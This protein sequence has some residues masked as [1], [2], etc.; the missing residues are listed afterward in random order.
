MRDDAS[1]STVRPPGPPRALDPGRP[2]QVEARWTRRALRA[3]GRRHRGR[4]R[5]RRRAR[6][7]RLAEP[8]RARRADRPATASPR[9]AGSTIDLQPARWSLRLVEGDASAS[10]AALCVVR[11]SEGRWL[12]GRRAAW[13]A[14]WPGRWALGAGGAVDVGESPVDTLVRE[15]RRGVGGRAG[16]RAGRGAGPPAARLVMFIG[17]AWL[18]PGAQVQMDHE[19]DDYAWWPADVGAWPDEADEPLRRMARCW[20]RGPREHRADRRAGRGALAEPLLHGAQAALVHALDDLRLPAG[21]LAHPRAGR[22]RDRSSGS[23]TG[24]AGSAWSC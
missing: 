1:C 3:A 23:R 18:A 12:A 22:G 21:R 11:D 10:V 8:R 19:H 17:Q 7:A 16:A 15:L 4:R 5:R 9:T 6:R 13:L 2:D 24:S 14:S 20:A